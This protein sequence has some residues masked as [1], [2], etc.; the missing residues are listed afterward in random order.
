MAI[1]IHS[2]S[3]YTA[4][5][6]ATSLNGSTS[7]L[8][9]YIR[10]SDCATKNYKPLCKV[11]IILIED[12]SCYRPKSILL[13]FKMLGIQLY[14]YNTLLIKLVLLVLVRVKT[15]KKPR[16]TTNKPQGLKNV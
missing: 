3:C 8:Q 1:Y 10:F 7:N 15:V 13:C 9:N 16:T 14:M 6:K 11:S 4:N 12:F 5:L 2:E